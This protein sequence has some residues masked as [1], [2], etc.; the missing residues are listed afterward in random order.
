[1]I[2]FKQIAL[3]WHMF[4]LH[5][6]VVNINLHEPEIVLFLIDFWRFGA[7]MFTHL[8][9]IFSGKEFS[10]LAVSLFG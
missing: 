8:R 7:T 10:A 3:T 5:G 6:V 4:T 1:M 2:K 9:E